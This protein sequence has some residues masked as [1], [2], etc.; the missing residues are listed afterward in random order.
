MPDLNADVE[1][2]IM[3][4]TPKFDYQWYQIYNCDNPNH[5]ENYM[6]FL[7]D[8]S[9]NIIF[10]PIPNHDNFMFYLLQKLYILDCVIHRV[11]KG[12]FTLYDNMVLHNNNIEILKNIEYIL[13]FADYHSN[14]N[15]SNLLSHLTFLHNFNFQRFEVVLE[16]VRFL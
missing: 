11:Y 1:G 15:E 8:I 13:M 3:D 10:S 9:L 7:D 12:K 16:I 6:L 4:F 2:L 14:Q 5:F